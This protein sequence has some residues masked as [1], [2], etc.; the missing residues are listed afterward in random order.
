MRL[1]LRFSNRPLGDL[2][3]QAV[4]V[5][6]FEPPSTEKGVL[7]GLN[8]KMP[9]FL[10]GLLRNNLLT[11]KRGENFLLS[12]QN[13]L[14][15]D[16][17]L[18]HGLGPESDFGMDLLREEI[19]Y[20]AS[21]LDKLRIR[22]LGVH[23]PVLE[24]LEPEYGSYLEHS[25]MD[26]I[27]TFHKSHGEDPDY[28]L[29]IIFSVESYPGPIDS[30]VQAMRNRFDTIMDLTIVADSKNRQPEEDAE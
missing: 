27:G 12:T 7:S 10:A 18:L 22:D 26:F 8:T 3:C 21:S 13:M 25:A 30:V 20:L 9:G 2:W 24:G 14:R 1:D 28:V 4:A 17:L 16:K 29:K 11:G 6:I 15:A 23:I 19:A 5:L